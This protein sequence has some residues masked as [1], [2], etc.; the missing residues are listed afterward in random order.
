M[1]LNDEIKQYNKINSNLLSDNEKI[2]SSVNLLKKHIKLTKEKIEVLDKNS[3]EFFMT[4][5]FLAKKSEDDNKD[6]EFKK[7]NSFKK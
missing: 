5:T 7:K 6:Y 3:E 2:K 4:L 1:E